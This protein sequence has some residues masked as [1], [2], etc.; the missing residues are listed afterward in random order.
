MM[1]QKKELYEM[2]KQE[3]YFQQAR[4][5]FL[6]EMK[7]TKDYYSIDSVCLNEFGLVVD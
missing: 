7:Y 3:Q 6:Q 1:K 4:M 2:V 5:K